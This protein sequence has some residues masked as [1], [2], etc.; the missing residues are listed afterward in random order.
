M[1]ADNAWTQF[2]GQHIQSF[3]P[4]GNLDLAILFWSRE[5]K[6]WHLP[7]GLRNSLSAVLGTKINMAR[8]KKPIFPRAQVPGDWDCLS[9]DKD[10]RWTAQL[11]TY[12]RNFQFIQKH[13]TQNQIPITWWLDSQLGA[14]VAPWN[15]GQGILLPWEGKEPMQAQMAT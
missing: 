10:S 6:E 3:F 12:C 8:V 4:T 11:A 9:G 1:L 13:E 5:G 14:P 7:S 15:S 2:K